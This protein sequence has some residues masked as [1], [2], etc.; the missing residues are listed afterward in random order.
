MFQKLLLEKKSMQTWSVSTPFMMSIK[1]HHPGKWIPFSVL[2]T[3]LS[4]ILIRNWNYTGRARIPDAENTSLSKQPPREYDTAAPPAATVSLRTDTEKR[5]EKWKANKKNPLVK[6]LT[7]TRGFLFVFIF[8]FHS[9]W[10]RIFSNHHY[11]RR[12]K[13]I[14]NRSVFRQCIRTCSNRWFPQNRF[15]TF[16]KGDLFLQWLS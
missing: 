1:C 2:H 3:F 13:I 14:Y 16:R 10:S 15:N 12:S 6:V 5:K 4:S 9:I 8:F 11:R 7:S